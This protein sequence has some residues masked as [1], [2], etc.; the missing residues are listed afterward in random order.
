VLN[1][2]DQ[3]LKGTPKVGTIA[4][5]FEGFPLDRVPIRA[6]TGTAEV[7]GKQTTSWVATY[8]DDYVVVMMVSQG[9]TGSGTSGPAVRKIWETLYGIKGSNV[10]LSKAA[11]PDGKPPTGLPEFEADGQ[12]KPPQAGPRGS[13]GG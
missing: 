1:Y 13:G 4:W 7:Y 12:I 10:D 2:I 11:L 6:K 5:R 8:D 9:G 3:A